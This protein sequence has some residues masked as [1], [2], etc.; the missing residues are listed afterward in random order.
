MLFDKQRL[1]HC[2]LFAFQLKKN[3]AEAQE[4]ICSALGENSVSYSTCKKHI[5]HVLTPKNKEFGFNMLLRLKKDDFLHKILTCDEK[6]VL[7]NNPQT[8]KS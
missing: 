6:W 4:M 1:R 8:R 7:Y 5:P 2:I 3:A